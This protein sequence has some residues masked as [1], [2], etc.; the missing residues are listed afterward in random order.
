MHNDYCFPKL[1]VVTKDEKLFALTKKYFEKFDLLVFRYYLNCELE[2]VR[3]FLI[4]LR[5]NLEKFNFKQL[6]NNNIKTIIIFP[7]YCSLEDISWFKN[8]AAFAIK[9]RFCLIIIGILVEDFLRESVKE[10]CEVLVDNL[11]NIN[12]VVSYKFFLSFIEKSFFSNSSRGKIFEIGN[13]ILI[14][15]FLDLNS[16]EF[17]VRTDSF[18]GESV[19]F[20]P[21][22]FYSYQDLKNLFFNNFFCF[23]KFKK[24]QQKDKGRIEFDSAKNLVF[25]KF[26]NLSKNFKRSA[27]WFVF[28]I[29]VF[30]LLPYFFFFLSYFSIFLNEKTGI[31]SVNNYCKNMV[32]LGGFLNNKYSNL[33][34]FN[35]FYKKIDV[36]YYFF[37][38][39][40]FLNDLENRM[41]LGLRR[42]FAEFGIDPFVFENYLNDLILY[43]R[44]LKFILADYQNLSRYEKFILNWFIDSRL[45]DFFVLSFLRSWSTEFLKSVSGDKNSQ[46]VLVFANNKKRLGFGAEIEKIIIIDLPYYSTESITVL[47]DTELTGENLIEFK[48]DQPY[49][50]L[51]FSQSNSWYLKNAMW[52]LDYSH[53]FEFLRKLIAEKQKINFD[54]IDHIFYIDINFLNSI[55]FNTDKT[56]KDE[57]Y[58]QI[59]SLINTDRIE[60]FFIQGLKNKQILYW[61]EDLYLRAKN[62]KTFSIIDEYQCS[63]CYKDLV[64]IFESDASLSDQPFRNV[65]VKI[66]FE[67]GT[68]KHKLIYPVYNEFPKVL[69]VLIPNNAGVGVVYL[70]KDNDNIVKEVLPVVEVN[71]FGKSIVLFQHQIERGIEEVIFTWDSK[72]NSKEYPLAS[73]YQLILKNQIGSLI[74]YEIDLFPPLGLSVFTDDFVLTENGIYKYN[75]LLLSDVLL[76]LNLNK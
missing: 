29:F 35:H 30:F 48:V 13:E 75:T 1:C 27:C 67:E 65:K 68:I 10:G 28:S 31:I 40:I 18:L 8:V 24:V 23:L 36:Y 56:D 76:K 60:K 14:E 34:Y 17:L 44:S 64:G 5:F 63:I 47:K 9:N 15:G 2:G 59:V 7:E 55:G 57:I 73:E 25:Y 42:V 66:S 16:K 4:D 50:L 45:K 52:D 71:N 39:Y 20:I 32:I 37:Y 21:D 33:P 51:Q 49:S 38:K 43:E 6:I 54:L 74:N 53:S 12:K 46:V 58:S 19:V 62:K 11:L 72:W 70:V 61:G 22:H 69:R 3:Y 41:K 26:F